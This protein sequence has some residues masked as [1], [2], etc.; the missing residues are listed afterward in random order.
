MPARHRIIPTADH[1]KLGAFL[2]TVR[3]EAGVSQRDLAAKLGLPQSFVSKIE[4]GERQL[5]A[6]ELIEICKE[7]GVDPGAFVSRYVS[8]KPEVREKKR[9]LRKRGPSNST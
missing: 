9:T 6:L 5:Q 1:A 7:I 8:A 2:R 3:L 4:R